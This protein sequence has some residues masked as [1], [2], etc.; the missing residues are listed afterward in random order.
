MLD[1]YILQIGCVPVFNLR[2]RAV[3]LKLLVIMLPKPMITSLRKKEKENGH[4]N[5]T[6]TRTRC[7]PGITSSSTVAHDKFQ[8]YPLKVLLRYYNMKYPSNLVPTS[9]CVWEDINRK[10]I[11]SSLT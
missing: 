1:G 6:T 7:L 11:G 5:F 4:T 3:Y 9:V 8:T 10:I 2:I